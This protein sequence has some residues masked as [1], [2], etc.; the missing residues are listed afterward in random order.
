MRKANKQRNRQPT[1]PAAPPDL[2]ATAG[3]LFD[4]VAAAAARSGLEV[5]LVVRASSGDWR[6]RWG[7]MPLDRAGNL[8]FHLMTKIQR[9]L[10]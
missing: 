5:I 6:S 3:K 2:D 7:A 8:V 1:P 9:M 10:P 4:D